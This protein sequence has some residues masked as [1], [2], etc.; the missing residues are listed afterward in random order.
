MT[1]YVM[2]VDHGGTSTKAVLFDLQGHAVASA[3]QA[4]R[5]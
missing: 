5:F 3:H 2:G 1:K 4:P